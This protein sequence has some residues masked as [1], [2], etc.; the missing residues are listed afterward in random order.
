MIDEEQPKSIP[1]EFGWKAYY[2]LKDIYAWLDKKIEQYPNLLTN[3][4][5][6]TTHENRTIRA[7]R[8]SH[9]EV[10]RTFIRNALRNYKIFIQIYSSQ[11]NPT[12]FLESTIHAREWITV[13]TATYFLNELLTSQD[14]KIKNLAQNFDWVI[15]PVLNVD[16]Y[17][18]THSDV[19]RKDRYDL[20]HFFLLWGNALAYGDLFCHIYYYF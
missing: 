3:Y 18:Y 20:C 11:G 2:P 15:V 17:E 7:V 5:V 1:R 8:L 4:A 14:A 19:S 10:S 9:K 16:G 13:A 12:I 6:G